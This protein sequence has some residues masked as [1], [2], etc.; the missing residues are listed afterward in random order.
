MLDK[1]QLIN[2]LHSAKNKALIVIDEAYIEFCNVQT[3]VNLIAEHEN[4]VILRTL[5]KAFALA[6]IRCG[7]SLAQEHIINMLAKVIAPYPIPSP[8]AK[9]ATQA[10]STQG[11][12]T[13]LTRVALLNKNRQILYQALQALPCVDT[14]FCSTANFLLVRFNDAP[15]VFNA[16]HQAGIVMRDFSN[17]PRLHNCIRISIGSKAEMTATLSILNSL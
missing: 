13:M 4:L 16:L 10:L 17:Q 3:L 8:V 6:S 11:I 15:T 2:L 7:F 5:S 12:Q 9:I 1:V 14:I